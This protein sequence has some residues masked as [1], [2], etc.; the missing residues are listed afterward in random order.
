MG[1]L[2][3]LAGFLATG[4]T[5]LVQGQT[6]F[7]HVLP[8]LS[9]E[10]L[11]AMALQMETLSNEATRTYGAK[12][13]VSVSPVLITLTRSTAPPDS[14]P[15]DYV[16]PRRAERTAHLAWELLESVANQTVPTSTAGTFV[17]SCSAEGPPGYIGRDERRRAVFEQRFALDY[18]PSTST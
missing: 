3:D 6:L 11:P 17:F 2:E 18:R 1:V 10:A 7:A 5:A 8:E 4:S 9:D 12:L 15:T 14:I 16:D 13:P